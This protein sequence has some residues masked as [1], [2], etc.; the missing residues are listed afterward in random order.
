MFST[1]D[2]N[3][4]SQYEDG[5]SYYSG[6]TYD[7]LL[8][9]SGFGKVASTSMNLNKRGSC[10]YLDSSLCYYYYYTSNPD[11]S[12]SGPTARIETNSSK[13]DSTYD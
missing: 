10:I 6:V 5:S 13:L 12:Y 1:I 7:R 11:N 4:I 2:G 8:L 9:I 3:L